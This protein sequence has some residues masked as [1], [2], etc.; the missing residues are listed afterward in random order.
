MRRRLAAA[1]LLLAGALAAAQAPPRGVLLYMARL[2]GSQIADADLLVLYESLIARLLSEAPSLLPIEAPAVGHAPAA[3]EERSR[4]ARRAGGDA[5]LWVGVGAGERTL[6]TQSC[7]VAAGDAVS[8]RVIEAGAGDGSAAAWDALVADVRTRFPQLPP[9][10]PRTGQPAAVQTAEVRIRAVAGTRISGLPV[11]DIVV[12]PEG[13]ANVTLDSP[14][15]Y[16]ITAT[17]SGYLPV[18]RSFFL[19][20][21]PLQIEC[22]QKPVS[23]WGFEA[24]LSNLAYPSFEALW[25]AV[26]DRVFVTLGATSFAVGVPLWA[27]EDE[28]DAPLTQVGASLNVYLGR[29]TGALR[30]YAGV[31]AFVRL[32][33]GAG[34]GWPGVELDGEAK[35]GFGAALGLEMARHP[36]LRPFVEL[37]PQAYLLTDADEI[38]LYYDTLSSYG[39]D[40]PEYVYAGPVLVDLFH[41]EAG[42]RI[43]L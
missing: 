21:A 16:R 4:E 17:H 7:D 40:T 30:P 11:E 42:V 23:R 9:A 38:E 22:G 2:P 10:Q 14:A 28:T 31:E 34:D 8:E 27:D 39:A 32:L 37:N 35:V 41:F 19:A 13:E 29:P 26:P 18:T 33:G 1:A 24:A 5:W 3:P 43:R 15:A 36:V 20:G 6:R 12:G 25:L